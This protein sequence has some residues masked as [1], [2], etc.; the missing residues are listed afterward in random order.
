MMLALAPLIASAAALSTP[1]AVVTQTG[2]E[3][4]LSNGYMQVGAAGSIDVVCC[5]ALL[6]HR[7]RA[8][9]EGQAIS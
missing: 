8:W 3:Y 4:C 5:K 6:C 1:P 7:V 2:T 9:T